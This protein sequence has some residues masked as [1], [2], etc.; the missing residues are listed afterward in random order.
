M[1]AMT[2]MMEARLRRTRRF[3]GAVRDT[4]EEATRLRAEAYRKWNLHD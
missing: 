1:A 2:K 3:L 4:F